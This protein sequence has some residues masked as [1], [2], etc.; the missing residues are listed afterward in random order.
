MEITYRGTV[1]KK[2]TNPYVNSLYPVGTT[3][4]V[5]KYWF[6]RGWMPILNTVVDSAIID[7][8]NVE[9]DKDVKVSL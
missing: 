9:F 8:K 5:D 6:D 2:F 1:V 7:F 3:L 4:E